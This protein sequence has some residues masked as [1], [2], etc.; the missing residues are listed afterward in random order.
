MGL[1]SSTLTDA[2][3]MLVLGMR[4]A[5]SSQVGLGIMS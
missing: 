2:I 4:I 5:V 1:G 3:Y